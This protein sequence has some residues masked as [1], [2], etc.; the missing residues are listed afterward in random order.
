MKPL[1]EK[2]AMFVDAVARGARRP[3]TLP[4][5]VREMASGIVT[6]ALYPFG[7]FDSGPGGRVHPT[8]DPGPPSTPVLL[9]H[10]YMAN[11]SN[12]YF[13]ERELRNVGIEH[14]HAMNYSAHRADVERLAEVC[15]LRAHEVMAATGSDRIHLVGHSLGGLVIR[16]AVQAG[17]LTE[18][19]SVVTVAT[20]HGGVDLARLTG[21]TRSRNMIAA[22][23]RPG[24]EFLRRMWAESHAMPDT[25]FVAYYSNL[26]L[27]VT[28]RRAMMLEPELAAT[29]I[30]MK[31]H[32]HLSVMLA[33]SLAASVA[34]E[35]A[36]ID[37]RA[38]FGQ[39]IAGLPVNVAASSEPVDVPVKAAAASR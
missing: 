39:P 30:L 17:G 15:V 11:K 10:G 23:L 22:Q 2:T 7:F 34:N 5:Q 12:W 6:G 1:L 37:G 36:A 20:P 3:Q 31:D 14:I 4:T 26:D 19:A 28:G 27:L 32:G 38:G 9:V 8:P 29:N 18:A 35:L 13:V 24:S 21:F 25:R 33:P 16:K